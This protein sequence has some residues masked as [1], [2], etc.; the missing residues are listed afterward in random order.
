MPLNKGERVKVQR[1]IIEKCGQGGREM[2]CPA[3]GS[4]GMPLQIGEDL[5]AA[6]V[7]DKSG[8]HL[9]DTM[10]MVAAA[11]DECGYVLFFS[12]VKMGIAS[13]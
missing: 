13:A 7:W 5:V 2:T 10:P 6:P 8:M 12:A 11:C 4:V 3:C 9:E 1:W